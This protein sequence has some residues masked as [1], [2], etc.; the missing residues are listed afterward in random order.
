MVIAQQQATWTSFP[1]HNP[2]ETA[3]HCLKLVRRMKTRIVIKVPIDLS[4]TRKRT[5]KSKMGGESIEYTN[6]H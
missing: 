6:V 3:R 2:D 4:E 5:T 1:N